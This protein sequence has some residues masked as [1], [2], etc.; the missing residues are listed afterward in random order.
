MKEVRRGEREGKMR[1]GGGGL[2]CNSGKAEI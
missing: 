2:N 1:G